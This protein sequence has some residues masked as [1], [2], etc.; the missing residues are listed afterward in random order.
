MNRLRFS[1]NVP[2]VIALQDP[3]GDYKPDAEQV[4]YLLSDGRMLTLNTSDATRL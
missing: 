1:P 2:Q 3:E 4:E